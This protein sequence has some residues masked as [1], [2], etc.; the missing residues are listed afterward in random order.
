VRNGWFPFSFLHSEQS[1]QKLLVFL[2]SAQQNAAHDVPLVVFPNQCPYG[3]GVEGPNFVCDEGRVC[4][5]EVEG[6]VK[7]LRD[8]FGVVEIVFKI[9]GIIFCEFGVKLSVVLFTS[10]RKSGFWWLGF[11]MA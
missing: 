9:V 5:D 8:V 3:S 6:V 4:E 7:M 1:D 10:K 11:S 2:N